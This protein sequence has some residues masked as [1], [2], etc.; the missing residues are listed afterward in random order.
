MPDSLNIEKVDV[1]KTEHVFY[2]RLRLSGQT[3]DI[4]SQDRKIFRGVIS[5]SIKEYEQIKTADEYRTKATKLYVENIEI[6]SSLAKTLA[7][8]ILES[9]QLFIPTDTLISSW[10]RWYL[11]CGSLIFEIKN[12]SNYVKQLFHCPWSQPDAVE[13]KDIILSNYNLLT[14]ELKLDSIYQ[15]FMSQLPKGKTYSRS[16]YGMTYMMTDKQEE[17]W[18]KDRPRRDYLKSLNDTINNYLIT[19]LKKQKI[20]FNNINCF[21]DYRLTFNENGKLSKHKVSDYSKPNLSDGLGFYLED[22]RGIRKCKKRIRKVFREID[23][24]SFNLKYKAYR[25]LS[26]GFG[27]QVHLRDDIF[28]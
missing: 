7:F 22:K 28:Y 10:T 14:Q 5:N 13:F 18:E 20:Q 2:F 21:Q 19:E 1:Q 6:D 23:L 9:G 25:T 24:S 11:H 12:E 8:Q 26:F 3:I 15:V 16:G 17:A 27:G 4:F